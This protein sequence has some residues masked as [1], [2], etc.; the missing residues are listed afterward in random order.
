[1]VAVSTAELFQRHSIDLRL[2][3]RYS[4]ANKRDLKGNRR[5]FA[6]RTTR[7]SPF[8][9]MISVPVIGAVGERVISYFG[10]FGKLDGW[11]ESHVEGGF[12]IDLAVA[13]DK[14]EQLAGKISW[15]EKQQREIVR[16]ARA[17]E[18]MIPENPH[19]TLIFADG[20]QAG[21]F[22]ID[23]SVSGAAVSADVQ[24]EIGS[25]LAVGRSVGRVIRHFREGFAVK[26]IRPVARDFL[27]QM[28]IKP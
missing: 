11:I 9:M 4:L 18:R 7:V 1:M 3:G 19:S 8:Q 13:K 14:R 23:M 5:E 12:M 25:P 16:D 2:G 21:C 15:L 22:V 6:C 17:Q 27:E 28:I 26:F 24:P 20:S 10:E